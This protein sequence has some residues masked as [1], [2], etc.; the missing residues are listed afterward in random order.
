MTMTS[1]A[2]YNPQHNES[3]RDLHG[4]N[5]AIAMRIHYG[6]RTTWEYR[7]FCKRMGVSLEEGVSLPGRPRVFPMAEPVECDGCG[8]AFDLR[9]APEEY[10]YG[11]GF[12]RH[13]PECGEPG[14][15]AFDKAVVCHECD[16]FPCTC[17]ESDDP[18]VEWL[19]ASQR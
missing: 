8:A 19:E 2:T 12:V 7:Q 1:V 3:Y 11:E 16:G 4:R 14:V 6:E 9:K 18:I 17:D 10:V 15:E 13:C 5:Y